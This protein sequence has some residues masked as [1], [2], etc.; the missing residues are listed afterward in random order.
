MGNEAVSFVIIFITKL[1]FFFNRN[2]STSVS[3]F[4]F[5]DPDVSNS[6]LEFV[7]FVTKC[8][9]TSFSVILFF[10]KETLF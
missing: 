5:G 2:V 7:S 1:I 9:E 6:E 10:F 8:H 3:S 4:L